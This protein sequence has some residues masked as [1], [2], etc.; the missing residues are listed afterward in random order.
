MSLSTYDRP[1]GSYTSAIPSGTRAFRKKVA[2]HFG[3]DRTEVVRDRSRCQRQRSEHC[4]CR[5]TD[6]FTVDLSPTG[7]GRRLFNWCVEHHELLDIDAVIFNRRV[8]GFG[9]STERDYEGASPHTD[10][11]HVSLSRFAAA[12]LTEALV[13][14]ALD[15]EGGDDLPLNDADLAKIRGVVKEE[16]KA[17]VEAF[18]AGVAAQAAGENPE[19]VSYAEEM[20]AIYARTRNLEYVLK[21]TLAEYPS[22]WPPGQ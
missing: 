7:N 8:V 19:V 2:A 22:T 4:E 12:N 17:Q 14:A 3:F 5:A 6:F 1:D 10:H 18:F 21:K 11:V 16:V 15:Q 20:R 9:N 13:Q